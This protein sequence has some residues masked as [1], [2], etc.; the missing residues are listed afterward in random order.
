[1]WGFYTNLF[2][3]YLLK[4]NFEIDTKQLKLD[5]AEQAKIIDGIIY[6]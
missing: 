1:M 3:K 2:Y 4:K 6:E 5:I